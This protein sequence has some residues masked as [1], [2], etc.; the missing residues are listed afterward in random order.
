MPLKNKILGWTRELQQS[1]MFAAQDMLRG[2]KF[3]IPVVLAIIP[4]ILQA[5]AISSHG[6]RL[7]LSLEAGQLEYYPFAEP[8]I[9]SGEFLAT[10]KETI[11]ARLDKRISS[12][13][14]TQS[15]ETLKA[16]ASTDVRLTQ[17]F[18]SRVKLTIHATVT[19]VGSRPSSL[20][21][22]VLYLLDNVDGRKETVGLQAFPYDNVKLPEGEPVQIG[23]PPGESFAIVPATRLVQYE[24]VHI[25]EDL[26]RK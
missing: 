2:K 17:L 25:I 22:L 12:L 16:D 19:N 5:V 4:M 23:P 11:R 21:Q 9:A 20:K 15:T 3:W 7:T 18:L 1:L 6:S 8:K 14:A 26:V 13:F 10:L 24:V